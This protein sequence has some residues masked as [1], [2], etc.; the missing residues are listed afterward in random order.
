MQVE[1][2]RN[3]AKDDK[4][5]N[6]SNSEKSEKAEE[7]FLSF[8]NYQRIPFVYVDQSEKKSSKEMRMKNIRRP[9]YIVHTKNF[10]YYIDVKYRK[11]QLFGQKDETRFYLN[12]NEIDE[13]YNF[14]T[15]LNSIV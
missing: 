9:D 4:Y 7:L 2:S 8:L 13:L 15:K 12:Q 14:Q 11:K 6:L 3:A 1:E 5:K 10:V